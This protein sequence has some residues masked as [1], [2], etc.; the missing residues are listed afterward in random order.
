LVGRSPVLAFKLEFVGLG[1]HKCAVPPTSGPFLLFFVFFCFFDVSTNKI[2]PKT[3][4]LAKSGIQPCLQVPAVFLPQYRSD[5]FPLVF[6]RPPNFEPSFFLLQTPLKKSS[7]NH[8]L[9]PLLTMLMA[10]FGSFNLTAPT[11]PS[12]L[13]AFNSF[14]LPRLILTSPIGLC[15]LFMRLFPRGPMYHLCVFVCFR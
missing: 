7:V 8:Q 12:S 9:A 4:K 6:P 13:T 11:H 1:K 15:F 14:F 10:Y 5:L 2:F 3:N